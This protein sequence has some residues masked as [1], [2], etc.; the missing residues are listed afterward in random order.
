VSI[1]DEHSFEVSTIRKVYTFS[2]T[3]EDIE[4]GKTCHEWVKAIRD[5]KAQ[6]IRENMGHAPVSMAIQK[7]NRAAAKVF[8]RRI[9]AD[10]R[11]G[12]T[13]SS[14]YNSSSIKGMPYPQY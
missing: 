9:L 8:E 13:D 4:G 3:Q 7:A 12:G 2:L 14:G 5:R 6:A 11:E 1:T 10:R